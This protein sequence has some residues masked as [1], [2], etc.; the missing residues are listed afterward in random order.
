MAET[1]NIRPAVYQSL[2]I[3]NIRPAAHQARKTFDE[4]SI[5]ALAESIR[6][7]G[8]IEPIIV[9]QVGDGYELISGERRL[10]AS[11]LLGL[12]T[13]EAKIIQTGSEAE[14]AAKGMVENLQRE[15][16][17]PIEEAEGFAELNRL[18]PG[19]WNQPKIAGITGRSQ[20]YISQSLKLLGLP[21]EILQSI[22]ALILS[23]SHGLEFLRLDTQEKQLEA[24]KQILAKKLSWEATRKLVSGMLTKK[25]TPSALSSPPG[26][27][28]PAD[29]LADVW[30]DIRNN[31]S[32]PAYWEAK[33]GVHKPAPGHSMTGWFFFAVP[34]GDNP[35][36]GLA[37]WFREMAD[38]LG[39]ATASYG[40]HP[41]L[42]PSRPAATQDSSYLGQ[43]PLSKQKVRLPQTPEEQTE[44]EEIAA[45]SPGPQPIYA[46]VYGSDSSMSKMTTGKTWADFAVQHPKEGL[47]Q[48]LESLKIAKE[49]G[50]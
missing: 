34:I 43:P 31:N 44:L 38:A 19:Y 4:D 15:D 26:S 20:A 18:D 32:I 45:S 13:I 5:K 46:W 30:A 10:R 48:L 28:A 17:N 49:H 16:L 23:M 33:Y 50:L 29:P 21:G 9:R 41:E 6:Q 35:K 25:K 1:A 47:K 3:D 12:K 42:P 22:R 24:L 7:E 39:I 8:L 2:P 36:E 14:A 27:H 37:G 11:K 40:G